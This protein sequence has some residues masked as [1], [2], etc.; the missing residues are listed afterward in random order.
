[1]ALLTMLPAAFAQKSKGEILTVDQLND[2]L[3]AI[4]NSY[5]DRRQ[6]LSDSY[7]AAEDSAL[8]NAILYQWNVLEARCG[9]HM[10][11]YCANLAPTNDNAIEMMYRLRQNV[12]KQ[13]IETI[14]GTLKSKQQKLP[15]AI[16]LR[17][18]LDTEQVVAGGKYVDFEATTSAGEPFSLRDLVAQKNVLLI[19]G[20]A[21]TIT[22]DML[23]W[24]Q[25]IYAR[26]GNSNLEV[27]RVSS[28]LSKEALDEQ[29]KLNPLNGM[30]TVSDFLGDH[31]P[32]R[33]AY[34]VQ[35]TPVCVAIAKG[36][37][38]DLWQV[39]LSENLLS[40]LMIY[41]VTE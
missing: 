13:L 14:Y 22:D 40:R 35:A 17:S 33:I 41:S 38:V 7:D 11:A 37:D 19:F 20:D 8:M 25:T 23:T 29:M 5:N 9:N 10:F 4:Y 39:G 27:V 30:L 15:Y 18:Y 12:D 28:A 36:G 2:S 24:F 6:E 34:D 1:M 3:V 26:N 16:D 31:S 21:E 32:A